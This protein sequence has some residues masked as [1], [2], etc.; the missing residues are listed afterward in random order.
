MYDNRGATFLP[1]GAIRIQCH[2]PCNLLAWQTRAKICW[3]ITV[4]MNL[5]S[6]QALPVDSSLG[7]GICCSMN[8]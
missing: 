3:S 1:W 2:A 8:M 6:S 4:A 5:A 7:T